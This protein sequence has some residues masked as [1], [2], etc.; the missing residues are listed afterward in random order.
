M[1]FSGTFLKWI[2]FF[3]IIALFSAGCSEPKHITKSSSVEKS[4]Q[5]KETYSE[6]LGIKKEEIKNIGLY[7]FIDDWYGVPYKYSGKNK[8][9]ID[10]SGFTC[11]LY[12]EVYKKLLA[13]SSTSIFNSCK[14]IK[15]TDLKEGDLVFFKINTDKISHIGIYLQNNKFVHASTQK[16]VIISG[17][18][19]D[20]YKKYF[21]KGG[22][23]N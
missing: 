4:E 19:E 7:Q 16:G 18:E 21:F 1:S 5:L 13:G 17:L 11:C 3:S 20:Y 15:K 10:C 6:I 8:N 14:I 23:L 2:C 9:G 12:Q 22:R